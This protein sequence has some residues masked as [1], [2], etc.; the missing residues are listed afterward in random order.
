MTPAQMVIFT[1]VMVL[2]IPCVA[3]LSALIKEYGIKNA[4]A[5]TMMDIA[6]ALFIG[7]AGIRILKALGF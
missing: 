1:L 3:T 6:L 2:Y 7:S 5:I 4:A